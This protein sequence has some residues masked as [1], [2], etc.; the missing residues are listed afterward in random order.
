[1]IPFASS[2][3]NSCSCVRTLSPPFLHW[4]MD[5]PQMIQDGGA[6]NGALDGATSPV[7]PVMMPSQNQTIPWLYLFAFYF[8]FIFF[9]YT[10][11][12]WSIWLSWKGLVGGANITKRNIWSYIFEPLGNVLIYEAI[13]QP[14]SNNISIFLHLQW[15][16]F[17]I[18]ILGFVFFLLI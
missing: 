2:M 12:F 10:L 9:E 3:D 16:S 6:P 1:M 11:F 5:D 4:Q 8:S 18:P 17:F 15:R 7:D 13:F 14:Y